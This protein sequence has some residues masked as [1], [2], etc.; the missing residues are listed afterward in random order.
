[1]T[2]L[3]KLLPSGA[4]PA[5][6]LL[7][8]A[9]RLVLNSAQRASCPTTISTEAGDVTVSVA[10]MRP[11]EVDD[12]FLD[13]KGGFWVVTP[14]SEKLLQVTGD[15]DVMREAAGALINRGVRVMGSGEGFAVLPLPNLAKML[16][17]VGLQ[18]EEIEAPFDPIRFVQAGGCCGGHGHG[19]CGCGGHHHHHDEGECGCGHHHHEDE[20]CCGEHKHEEGECCCGGHGHD[21]GECCGHGKGHGHGEC[22]CG[23][24]KHE[25]GEC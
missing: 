23:E 18:V 10:D 24:H 14:A 25:E 21:E 15:V 20:C 2:T 19:G 8:K 22:G 9:G 11:L 4:A 7:E 6:T 17:M 5:Q 12:V 13:D 16:E 3:T 1:M